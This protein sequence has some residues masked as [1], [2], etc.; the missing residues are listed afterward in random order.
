MVSAVSS[1]VVNESSSAAR[2]LLASGGLFCAS[3]N[4]PGI[5][6]TVSPVIPVVSAPLVISPSWVTR[7][8]LATG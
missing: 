5:G 4:I 3:S 6:S 1:E 7:A 2:S 8:K